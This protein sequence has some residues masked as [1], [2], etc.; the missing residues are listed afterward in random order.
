[1]IGGATPSIVPTVAVPPI[2]VWA[3]KSIFWDR[4]L[5]PRKK[6]GW[7]PEYQSYPYTTE[8]TKWIGRSIASFPG[9]KRNKLAS[10][11]V[12][13]SIVG[14]WTGGLGRHTLRLADKVLR[15][16]GILPDPPA[17][18]WTMADVPFFKA[19]VI[20]YPSAS[21]Q[22]IQDFYENY[23][24]QSQTLKTIKGLARLG[25]AEFALRE[26]KISGGR[27]ADIEQ[28]YQSL[29]NLKTMVYLLWKNP[30][31][32]PKEKQAQMDMIYFNMIAVAK[33]GNAMFD[34]VRSMEVPEGAP[35]SRVVP[36]QTERELGIDPRRT[37]PSGGL[38]IPMSG[39]TQ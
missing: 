12:I 31:V 5:I 30:F 3:D 6:Q 1:M 13:D 14:N 26:L 38:V 20:R 36:T 28:S 23:A 16:A 11:A 17:P 19:F 29:S 2:E 7:Y 25:E 27:F 37:P 33:V 9:M 15:E 8:L 39:G 18:A 4:P 24:E 22:S 21:A 34:A 10:P 32:G 35:V